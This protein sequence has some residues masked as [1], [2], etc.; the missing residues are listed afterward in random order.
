MKSKKLLIIIS[1]LFIVYCSM[2]IAF[3]VY[4]GYKI[5]VT[6]PHGP[7]AGTEPTLS[8]YIRGIYVFALALVI[9]AAL[10]TLVVGGFMYMLSGTI[11]TQEKAKEYIWA[12]IGGL[13]LALAA[14]LILYTIN[15]DL[16]KLKEPDLNTNGNT[17]MLQKTNSGNLL[18]I[19][20]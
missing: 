1:L 15:P 9:I 5:E 17:S 13:I 2:L 14:Y 11:T 3:N 4:A 12:A 18:V 19:K 8:S 20:N 7:K 6:I 16:T 10:G